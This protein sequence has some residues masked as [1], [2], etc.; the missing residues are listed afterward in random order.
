MSNNTILWGMSTAVEHQSSH[1]VLLMMTYSTDFSKMHGQ[2]M[3]L[4]QWVHRLFRL[5]SQNGK[6][7]Q[8]S[9]K[10]I[11]FAFSLQVI[12]LVL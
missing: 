4:C 12:D 1:W 9:G 2:K 8:N 5:S 6:F 10:I 7:S 3:N 11:A